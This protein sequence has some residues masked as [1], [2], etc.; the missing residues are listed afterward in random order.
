MEPLEFRYAMLFSAGEVAVVNPKHDKD[1]CVGTFIHSD[2]E[3]Q[4]PRCKFLWLFDQLLCL[5]PVKGELQMKFIA[6]S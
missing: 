5:K 2:H 1:V 3:K 4:C 6:K